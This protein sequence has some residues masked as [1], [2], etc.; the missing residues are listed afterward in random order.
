MSS[1]IIAFASI[2]LS[3]TIG[4]HPV[5]VLVGD[6]VH[7]VEI[8]LDRQ[9]IDTLRSPRWSL[10]ADFG[11]DLEPHRLRA[12]A[13]DAEGEKL[14][15]AEQWVNLP[16]PTAEADLVI[17]R[18]ESGPPL[19]RLTWTNIMGEEPNTVSLSLDG[20]PVEVS[21]PHRIELP[22]HNLEQLHFLRTELLFDHNVSV[23]K[24]VTFGGSYG[25]TVN[26]ELTAIAIVVEDKKARLPATADLESWFLASREPSSIA[27]IDEGPAEIVI[28][29]DRGVQG[30]LERLVTGNAAGRHLS[31]AGSGSRSFHL[32]R[33]DAGLKK[34]QNLAFFWPFLVQAPSGLWTFPALF[35]WMSPRDGGVGWFL[36]S[37]PP[38][39][40][41]DDS[42]QLLADAV[43]VA[44]MNTLTR[45]RRRAVVLILG[46]ES[47]DGSRL[48]PPIVR[49]YLERLRVP[50]LVWS[51]FEQP[52]S[53]WGPV[54]LISSQG[55]LRSA[56]SGLADT[57]QR[58]R[59]I[60]FHGRHLPQDIRL[61]ELA[62]KVEF[63]R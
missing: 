24:E 15:S 13:F 31:G 2:F 9:L 39:A 41:P 26:T 60:W 54:R 38:P 4:P 18:P 44:G 58:Q 27:A 23:V 10:Q 30:A 48:S 51:P 50:L 46:Q 62:G 29:R 45:N 28:I 40:P 35:G 52:D 1:T 21:D 34:E 33:F 19:A 63:P 47:E 5:E 37:V 12:I 7:A 59:I 25:E 49:R 11:G 3:L 32:S 17:E 42:Q 57:V 43:A 53:A 61:T 55:G 14:A 8:W 22:P 16:R 56:V 20:R 36:S 6:E